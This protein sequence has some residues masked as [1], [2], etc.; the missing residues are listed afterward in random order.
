MATGQ[1]LDPAVN[2]FL[3]DAGHSA[4]IHGSGVLRLECGAVL[5]ARVIERAL[6]RIVLPPEDIVAV[7]GVASASWLS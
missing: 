2:V 1:L 3:D 4:R 7:V 6:Q 5:V